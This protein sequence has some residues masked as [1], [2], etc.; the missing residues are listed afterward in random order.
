MKKGKIL[1]FVGCFLISLAA[2][3]QEDYA[4][5]VLANKGANE[6]KSGD[7]WQPLKTGAQLKKG[8]E[9]KISEN[10]S[11]GLVSYKGKPLE[12]KEPKVHKVADLLEKVGTSASVLNKYTDFILSSN[13]A[14]AKKNRLSA[15]GAVHR[16]LEDIKVFLPENQ[17]AE[18]Y[19][20]TAIINWQA[21]K[22]GA[23]YIVSLKNMFDEELTKIETS[24]NSVQ[25][26]M[27]D[28]KLANESAVLVEVRSKADNK[29][30]S[31]QHLIK[32]LSPG[33]FETV[34][35][36]L[37]STAADLQEATAFN[38]YLLAG[39]YEENKL[40]IDAI[41]CYEQAIKMDPENPTYKEAYE[42]FLLRNKLK[43]PK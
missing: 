7:T 22:G 31:E 29:S 13:S 4:F 11:V 21:T 16:G 18:I 26:D 8:D 35:A 17:Y 20:S 5:R 30:K 38:K 15:T 32:K 36:D 14:E 41:T 10:S 19:N 9:L 28:P 39:F 12:V 37:N 1:A 6:V 2:L 33:R 40:F 24:E 27:N 34:K 43:N 3:A 42:E 23:P 25:I